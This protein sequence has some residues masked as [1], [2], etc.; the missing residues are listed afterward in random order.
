MVERCGDRQRKYDG[1]EKW[2]FH[3]FVESLPIM[4]QLSLLLLA[5]GLCRYTWSINT[6]VA[7]VLITLTVLGILFYLGIV[8]AGTS[9]YECPFQTPASTRL[10]SLWK[11]IQSHETLLTRPA[12][13][14]GPLWNTVRPI[15]VATHRFKPIITGVILDFNQWVRVPFG[16]RPHTNHLSPVISLG[17]IREDPHA[18]PQPIPPSLPSSSSSRG[19]DSPTTNDV[20]P[21]SLLSSSSSRGIDSPTTNDVVPPPLLGISSIHIISPP[22]TGDGV[23]LRHDS[24]SSHDISM[25]IIKLWLTPENLASIQK[26]NAKDV[27][28]V[29]WIL[30]NITDPEALDAA[31]RFAG[32]VLWFEHGINVEPPYSVIVSIFRTCF[33]STGIVYPALLERAYYSALA[34]LWINIHASCVSEELANSFPLPRVEKAM[35]GHPDLNFLL[36]LFGGAYLS[37]PLVYAYTVTRCKAHA[38]MQWTLYAILHRSWAE[39]GYGDAYV[40]SHMIK[41]VPWN[42]IPLDVTLNL[43]LVCSISLGY[44]LE[45]EALKIQ[46]KTYAVPGF[47]YLSHTH[48]TISSVCLARVIS[49]LSR[50]IVTSILTPTPLLS[51]IIAELTKWDSRPDDLRVAAH[52]WCSVISKNYGDI[53]DGEGLMFHC[54]EICFRGLDLDHRW[55]GARLPSTK[56]YQRVADIVSNSGGDE[57]IADLLQAWIVHSNSNVS[58]DL[59]SLWAAYLIRLRHVTSFSHRLRRLAIDSIVFLGYDHIPR[60][61]EPAGVEGIIILLDR[62]GIGIDE[63]PG[64]Y[65]KCKLLILLTEVVRSPEGRRSLSY[66]YWELIPELALGSAQNPTLDGPWR[67]QFRSPKRRAPGFVNYEVHVMVSLEEEQEWEKLESWMGFVWFVLRPKTDSISEDVEHVTLSLLRQRPGAAKKL[68][69]WLQRVTFYYDTPECLECL[70]RVCEWAGLEAVSRQDAS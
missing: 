61:C 40:H 57:T 9:S 14:I 68:K 1:L 63:I 4:L 58:S 66:P 15:V 6:S 34:M 36:T 23:S 33:D 67:R 17:E 13:A 2:P 5:C 24:S 7:S 35:P 62:L 70:Q 25:E 46:D 8:A 10:R 12:V 28:C 21:P 31:I 45:G 19:I 22:T 26:T 64:E 52:E 42:T 41:D 65:D 43:L 49:Q 27:R 38:H 11:V 37:L 51:S 56:H 60:L 20:V 54:L 53:S 3:L 59:L 18:S 48:T 55:P 16:L 39:Q 44:P 29:S 69:Q 50:A 30:R 32:T 47:Y